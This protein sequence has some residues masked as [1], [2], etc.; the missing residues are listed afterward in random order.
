[1]TTRTVTAV[2]R[3]DV[4]KF[5]AD[6]LRAK[7]AVKGFATETAGASKSSTGAAND[8]AG[9]SA[10]AGLALTA[11]LALAGKA[12][13]DWE[14]SWAGVT[15]TVDG[16][17]S[18]MA[19]L[20]GGLRDLATTLPATHTEIAAVAEAAGQ[21]GVQRDSIIGFTETMIA[22]GE[23]TNLS[24]EEAATSLAQISNVMGTMEREGTPGIERLGSTI[25][26]LGNAGAST[27]ADIVAM[28][29]RLTGAA[30][31]IGASESDVLALANAMSSVGIEAQL[32]GGV[33]SRVM[34]E[35]NSEVLAGG[36]N[37]AGFAKIAGLSA[38]EFS[39][40]WKSDPVTAIDAFVKGL[41][42]ITASGG[43]AVG[44]L[45]E[46]GIKGTE[47][48]SV[49][50]RLAG[51]SDILTESITLGRKAW[52]ENTALQDEAGKRYETTASQIK[53]ARNNAKDAAIDFGAVLAPAI[54]KASDAVSGLAKFMADLPPS[55]QSGITGV[56]GIG[57]AG[58]LAVA[59]V[60]KGTN[61][62]LGMKDSLAQLGIQSP[63]T[64]SALG[65]VG[66]A[67][68]I[69]AAL[70]AAGTVLDSAFGNDGE[71]IGSE[72]LTKGMLGNADAVQAFSDEIGRYQEKSAAGWW[73]VNEISDYGDALDAAFNPSKRQ[74]VDNM[75]AGFVGLFGIADQSG[76]TRAGEAFTAMDAQLS[77]LVSGGNADRAAAQFGELAKYAE[78][79][80]VSIDELKAKFPQYGEALDK[81]ANDQK[82]AGDSAKGMGKGVAGTIPTV[83]EAAEAAEEYAKALDDAK[84][85]I[86]SLGGGLRAEQQ[87]VADSAEA[88]K[89][90]QE[91]V[92]G[93]TGEQET[94]LRN[95]SAAN[96]EVS[97]A[98][99]EMGRGAGE[100]G[101]TMQANRD[102]FIATAI[103]MGYNATYA[104]QLADEYG[105]IPDEVTTLVK[106][107]GVET[108]AQKVT[109][110]SQ[111]IKNDLT[112]KTITIKEAGA[113]PSKQRVLQL[114]GAIFGL[115]GKTV[116][117]KELGTTA[118]GERIVL[119]QGK[120]YRLTGKTVTVAANV[121]GAAQVDNLH[122]KIGRLQNRTI[123]VATQFYSYN[124]GGGLAEG[125]AVHGAGTSTSDSILTRLSNNEHVLTAAEVA[126]M[127][128][129]AE[130]YAMR[131]AIR[132][133]NIPK[134]ADGGAVMSTSRAVQYAARPAPMTLSPV[135]QVTA[136]AGASV[137][138]VDPASIRAMAREVATQTARE[139][140]DAILAAQRGAALA[141]VTTR[142]TGR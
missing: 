134:F 31:L 129:H 98:Q 116:P 13:I 59:G 69:L 96:L 43:D 110:L 18:Q 67:A 121:Q 92:K 65:K 94:A 68:G 29:T 70:L 124:T 113:D 61:A 100:V 85:A 112:G 40:K 55:A 141:S 95:L 33:M 79:N 24:A 91:S 102:K 123:T 14:S 54:V 136:P 88:Y 90:A 125:G 115:K 137:A 50:T 30:K 119:F 133:G 34:Q 142:K 48:T 51:A 66:K 135:V 118:S 111:F 108:V 114:D 71:G 23:S 75:A 107:I 27:E 64:A 32:G 56:A 52:Q 44:A 77:K 101:A 21:L 15:K 109:D 47:N 117:V 9:A 99:L 20:E 104:A 38:D 1:M 97:A 86:I 83:E 73:N 22:M 42:G 46:V 12:A 139:T 5:I 105:L 76:L 120:I 8:V 25:V 132:A 93:T 6:T 60:V 45:E 74:Q 82:L 53:I 19:E 3:A 26:A 103:A 58:L 17:A 126:A 41:G 36:D 128:G 28:A 49:L 57:A 80:G 89:A 10:K 84:S 63:K 37:L 35:I 81:I 140:A 62:V 130:V 72:G 4:D 16:S 7:N 127:G 39:A 131:A 11:G 106:Q 78:A 138:T 2:Y 87:A 122:A